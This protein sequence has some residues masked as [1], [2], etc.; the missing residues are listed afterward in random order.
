MAK[1]AAEVA[2]L[3][4]IPAMVSLFFQA[5]EAKCLAPS[6]NVDF[7]GILI[8]GF[9]VTPVSMPG[10]GEFL[11]AFYLNKLLPNESCGFPQKTALPVSL[12]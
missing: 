3:A 7:L 10:K 4:A 5:P 1:D 9:Y 12:V 2:M 11:L 6:H 8:E